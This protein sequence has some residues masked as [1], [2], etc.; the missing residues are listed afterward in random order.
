MKVLEK[1]GFWMIPL[2]ALIILG[3]IYYGPFGLYDKVKGIASGIKEYAPNITVGMNPLKA[4]PATI[5]GSQESEVSALKATIERMLKSS[6][7]DCFD[8]FS[9]FKEDLGEGDKSTK[10]SIR[11]DNLKDQS[12]FTITNL[13]GQTVKVFKVPKMK[14]CVIAGTNQAAVTFLN[15]F[16]GG[17]FQDEPEIAFTGNYYTLVNN[18]EIY[19]H[20]YY[21]KYS[22][23]IIRV[24]DWS[25]DPV[26]DESDNFQSAGILFKGKDNQ[27]C[28]FPTNKAAD[29]DKDGID[30]D[31]FTDLKDKE[32]IAYQVK[33][34]KRYTCS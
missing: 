3:L 8:D 28:F 32:S 10:I 21:S 2:V 14:P 30:N 20:K 12:V 4:S 6:K 29:A 31:Q 26:N 23:N 5:S 33:I 27:I 15:T 13:G 25:G 19:Y 16:S 7:N 17:E 34:E 22:G 9:G 18:L 11:Y 24:L 1:L